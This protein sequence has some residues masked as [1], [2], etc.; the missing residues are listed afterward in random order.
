LIKD[1]FEDIKKQLGQEVKMTYDSSRGSK[2][3]E[4]K[5]MRPDPNRY[6]EDFENDSK[7]EEGSQE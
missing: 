5:T 4:F 3:S 1:S 7:A 6:K 2:S